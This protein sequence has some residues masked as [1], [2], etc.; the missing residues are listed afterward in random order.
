[1]LE[2]KDALNLILKGCNEKFADNGFELLTPVTEEN[3]TAFADFKKGDLTLRL[4]SH[5]NLLDV[6]EKLKMVNSLKQNQIFLTLTLLK[7]VILSHFAMSLLTQLQLL[8]V[9]RQ[10]RLQK[11][12]RRQFQNLLLKTVPLMMLILSQTELQLFTLNLKMLTKKTS[13][14]TTS[15]LVKI[16]L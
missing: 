2:R 12:H 1:M 7:S 16:S 6:M 14:N 11:K 10:S 15:F 3:E 8:T 13:R 5:D 9:K 4:L